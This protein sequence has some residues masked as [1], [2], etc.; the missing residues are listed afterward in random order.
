MLAVVNNK[1]NRIKIEWREDACVG[2]V[3]ASAGYPG[4][5]QT[6]FPVTGL[7]EVDED[8]LVFHAGTKAGS[9]PGQVL[10]SGGR[11]LTVVAAGKTVNEARQKVYANISRIKFQGCQYRK[12]IARIKTE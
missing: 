7:D 6:G 9:A 8:I 2:V 5:Y 1:L 11:V 3:M 4:S 12:D 10:T